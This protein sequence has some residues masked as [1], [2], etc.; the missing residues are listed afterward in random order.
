[1]GLLLVFYPAYIFLLILLGW[2]AFP[3]IWVWGILLVLPFTAW[4]AMQ[5][6]ESRK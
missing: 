1:V 6:V 5:V 3:G 4:A 2:L